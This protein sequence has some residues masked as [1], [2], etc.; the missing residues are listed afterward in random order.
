MIGVVVEETE[1]GAFDGE[2]LVGLIPMVVPSDKRVDARSTLPIFQENVLPIVDVARDR[3]VHVLFTPAA[4]TIVF[5]GRGGGVWE[6]DLKEEVR[7]RSTFVF[8]FWDAR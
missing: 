7:G 4:E 8:S 6:I 5:V 1:A 3:A 2:G